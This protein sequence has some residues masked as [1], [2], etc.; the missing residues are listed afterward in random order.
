M[1]FP[2]FRLFLLFTVCNA[3][4]SPSARIVNG[5]DA[6]AESTPF[7][8]SIMRYGYHSCGGSLINH[9]T[10]LTAAHCLIQ[11]T[12][13]MLKVRLGSKHIS[14]GGQVYKVEKLEIH[15]KFNTFTLNYDIAYL[16][17]NQ[18]VTITEN[19]K[20]ITLSGKRDT[21]KHGEI[22]TIYGWGIQHQHFFKSP[23]FLQYAKVPIIDSMLCKQM[24][25][26]RISGAMFCAGYIKGGVD[27]CQNDS[28]G[29]L[30]IN[31]KLFGIVSWGNGCAMPGNPGVYTHV[32]VVRPW[33]DEIL[34]KHY[35]EKIK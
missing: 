20:P 29:P 21:L 5:Y 28:G 26:N 31:N 23:T 3:S 18:S 10:V 22:A 16:R 6:Q 9:R 4:Q 2:T 30:I 25:L 19:V 17:L 8:V 34:L 32:S 7:M 14:Q 15:P 27:A 24:M 11:T 12:E 35:H 1:N 33:I 13:N